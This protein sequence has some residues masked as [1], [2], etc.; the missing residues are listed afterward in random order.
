MTRASSSE[1]LPSALCPGAVLSSLTPHVSVSHCQHQCL[2]KLLCH[3]WLAQLRASTAHDVQQGRLLIAI[4]M[5][6]FKQLCVVHFSCADLMR[7]Q[8]W[9]CVKPASSWCGPSSRASHPA[10]EYLYVLATFSPVGSVHARKGEGGNRNQAGRRTQLSLVDC[11]Y[12]E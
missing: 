8:W 12:L 6:L 1:G 3:R 4:D 2:R 10:S 5:A 7:P 9:C 11:V